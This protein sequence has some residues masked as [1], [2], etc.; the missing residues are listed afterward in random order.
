MWLV[1]ST[2]THV[3]QDGVCLIIFI[4][5]NVHVLSMFTHD[6]GVD[7]FLSWS[8]LVTEWP[9]L[10]LAFCEII[11]VQQRDIKAELWGPSKSGRQEL[12]VLPHLGAPLTY[13]SMCRI[14][15]VIF[16]CRIH[17]STAHIL[18]RIEDECQWLLHTSLSFCFS[19]YGQI[20]NHYSSLKFVPSVQGSTKN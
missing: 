7:V 9:C 4:V 18:D 2:V 6:C 19:M 17:S 13:C 1:E 8:I 11:Y 3:S 15:W 10:M 5:E 14:H 16:C 20:Y 12:H